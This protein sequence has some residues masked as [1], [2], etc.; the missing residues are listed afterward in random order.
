MELTVFKKPGCN[1]C[2][3]ML[4]SLDNAGL[5][6]NII[7]VQQ[8][9]DSAKTNNVSLTPTVVVTGDNGEEVGRVVGFNSEKLALLEYMIR[10]AQNGSEETG[11]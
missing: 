7:D 1:P 8:N 11:K 6:Y 2:G 4:N 5:S 9:P 10:I 3:N